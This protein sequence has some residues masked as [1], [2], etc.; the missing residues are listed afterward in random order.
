MEDFHFTVIPHWLL[1]SDASQGAIMLYLYLSATA[2]VT[3]GE[4]Y[5]CTRREVADII[6]KS[7]KTTDKYISELIQVGAL[8]K[9]TVKDEF[10]GVI[11]SHYITKT[12]PVPVG[13]RGL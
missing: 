8:T 1:N 11:G 5:M 4:G 9:T 13:K 7:L 3:K 6:G 2:Q 10:G 12:L